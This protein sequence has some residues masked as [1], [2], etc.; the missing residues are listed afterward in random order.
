MGVGAWK[1]ALLKASRSCL[2]RSASV[3]RRPREASE[4]PPCSWRRAEAH[5]WWS[6]LCTRH[7]CGSSTCKGSAQ[8]SWARSSPQVLSP[9][10]EPSSHSCWPQRTWHQSRRAPPHRRPGP[11][12]CLKRV[13][14]IMFHDVSSIQFHM[15]QSS[16]EQNSAF[17]STLSRLCHSALGWALPALGNEACAKGLGIALISVVEAHLALAI[18]H[19]PVHGGRV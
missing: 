12:S 3:V 7:G 5:L 10:W 11:S 4:R 17:T 6:H 19:L 2:G 14:F 1:P 13:Y 18:A 16:I 15:S 9:V 8:S